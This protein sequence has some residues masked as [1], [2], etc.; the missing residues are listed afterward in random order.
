MVAPDAAAIQLSNRVAVAA[1]ATSE[2]APSV[3]IRTW[4]VARRISR[5]GKSTCLPMV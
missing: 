1:T 3:I 2:A 5:N 4:A